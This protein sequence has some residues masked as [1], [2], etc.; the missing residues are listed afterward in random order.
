MVDFLKK[1]LQV[2]VSSTY[3]DLKVER[4][5]GVEA[6]L[7]AGHIPAGM[8]LFAAGDESQMEVIKQWINQSD[9]FLLI[10]AGRYGSIDPKTGRSY[11]EVE[12]KYALEKG[13]ALFSC[14]IEQP[15]LDEKVRRLG[16]E[17][18]ETEEADKL[19]EF[20]DLVQKK[21]VGFWNDEKDIQL[22]IHQT[23]GEFSRREDLEGWV[24]SSTQVNM[25]AVTDEITRLSREN[26]LL[27]SQ[28]ESGRQDTL[29]N[30]LTFA[31]LR[32][33]VID[34]GLLEWMEENRDQLFDRGSGRFARSETDQLYRLGLLSRTGPSQY[35][36]S[37]AGRIFFNK[38]E[39]E[40][41]KTA[42]LGDSNPQGSTW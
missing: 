14:V 31:E 21:T 40:K 2:F 17:A 18:R 28:V 30:G 29:L 1:R 34:K 23:L 38:L 37:N 35:T 36:I 15:A 8:E 20:R 33:I 9:V 4:Q 19:A 41:V 12:Y 5:A 24:R 6:I 27:R 16:P 32:D 7:S 25:P 26:S 13:L 22:S 39:S 10:L 3:T 42:A 11:I